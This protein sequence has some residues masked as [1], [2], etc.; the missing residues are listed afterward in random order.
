MFEAT[1]EGF[2][3]HART[4]GVDM[5]A[6]TAALYLSEPDLVRLRVELDLIERGR[7][8]RNGFNTGQR[9]RRSPEEIERAFDVLREDGLVPAA[10]A[11]KLGLS[12]DALRRAVSRSKALRERDGSDAQ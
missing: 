3:A 4:H 10:I 12:E 6:D 9:R 2:V 5:V 8:G 7:K 1:L 11:D